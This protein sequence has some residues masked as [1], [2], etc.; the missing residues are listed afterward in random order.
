MWCVRDEKRLLWW[1]RGLNKVIMIV[2]DSLTTCLGSWL[3]PFLKC[4][5]ITWEC[6][7]MNLAFAANGCGNY[8]QVTRLPSLVQ[9]VSVCVCWNLTWT[10]S[11]NHSWDSCDRFLS[12][13]TL[14]QTHHI[15][16]R[17]KLIISSTSVR[18]FSIAIT[19]KFTNIYIFRD[20]YSCQCYFD[21]CGCNEPAQA[22]NKGEGQ[23][24]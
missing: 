23:A 9:K 2:S 8:I 17:A 10:L 13:A 18:P 20:G 3:Q 16:R 21:H 22:Y 4:G 1:F 12:F 7:E 5:V 24:L 11:P 15:Y 14:P 19:Y 6:C